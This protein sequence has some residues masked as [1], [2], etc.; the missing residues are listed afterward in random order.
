MKMCWI[1]EFVSCGKDTPEKRSVTIEADTE[2]EVASIT[3]EMADAMREKG[4]VILSESVK[5]L[6]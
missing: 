3:Q 5:M 1:I 6:K 2:Q 4:V